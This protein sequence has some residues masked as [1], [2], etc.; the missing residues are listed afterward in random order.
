MRQGITRHRMLMHFE[1][2]APPPRPANRVPLYA[3]AEAQPKL[4]LTQSRLGRSASFWNARSRLR[5]RALP[6]LATYG[7]LGG[8][9]PFAL[10]TRGLV[11]GLE[12][13]KV[14]SVRASCSE[15]LIA[16]SSSRLRAM[17]A[18]RCLNGSNGEADWWRL[19]PFPATSARHVIST[20]GNMRSWWMSGSRIGSR[21]LG[22]GVSI[23]ACSV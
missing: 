7:K 18:E 13:H 12:S 8:R 15:I 11:S 5:D 6:A 14:A 2:S 23:R 21:Q 3:G 19:V 17:G 10:Q 9:D 1:R 22:T 20:R 4:P 16:R